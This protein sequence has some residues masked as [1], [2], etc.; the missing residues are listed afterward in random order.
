MMSREIAW[1]A[2]D[3][4]KSREREKFGSAQGGDRRFSTKEQVLFLEYI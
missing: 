4:P 1:K 2:K 3:R